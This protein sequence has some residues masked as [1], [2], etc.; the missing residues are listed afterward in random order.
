VTEKNINQSKKAILKSVQNK[1]LCYW[2]DRVKKL[3]FQGN[4]IQLLIEEKQNITWQSITNNI[5]KGV[6]SFALKS[7]VNGLNTPDNLKRWGIRQMDKCDICKNKGDLQ[8]ILNWCQIALDQGRFTWR[9]NSVLSHLIKELLK[10]KPENLLIYADLPGYDFNGGTIPPDILTTTSRP[11]IV[12]VE[13]ETKEIKL[14]ELTCSFENNIDS[15]NTTKFDKY[16]DLKNDLIKAGWKTELVP[17]EVGS[18]GYISKR[19]IGSISK[20]ARIAHIKKRHKKLITEI[21]QVSLLCSFTVFQSLS[22]PTWQ[23]PPYLHP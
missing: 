14:F 17:F 1:T 11:D 21:S 8:H 3:A 15:A 16:N 5:P 18:R 20:M 23:E 7:S 19:N 10:T 2:N 13:R 6:L 4:F 9:H 22:Q 12:F